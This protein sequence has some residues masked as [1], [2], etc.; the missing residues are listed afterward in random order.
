MI[1]HDAFTRFASCYHAAVDA[2]D[3]VAVR[4]APAFFFFLW[5]NSVDFARFALHV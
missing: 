1:L 2:A 4:R 3:G 5:R